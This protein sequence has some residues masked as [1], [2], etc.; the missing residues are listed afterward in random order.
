MKSFIC[1]EDR[2]VGNGFRLLLE[3]KSDKCG[4]ELLESVKS[5][6]AG[7]LSSDTLEKDRA[8]EATGG[9]FNWGDVAL[10]LPRDV[11]LG[12]GFEIV[13]THVTDLVTEHDENLLPR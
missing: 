6:V 2:S 12:H 13:D 1:A 10:W 9:S 3:I 7:F 4:Q 11:M 5:A 8:M